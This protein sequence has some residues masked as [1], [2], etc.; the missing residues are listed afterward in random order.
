MDYHE[1]ENYARLRARLVDCVGK[2]SRGALAYTT[3]L[4]PEEGRMCAEIISEMKQTHKLAFFGGYD[5]AERKRAFILPDY[6]ESF[7]G[8]NNE[9]LKQYFRDE[10]DNLVSAVSITGSGYRELS[11]RDYMGSVLNLGIERDA[12]GDIVIQDKYSAVV[13]GTPIVCS[14]IISELLRVAS[15]KVSVKNVRIDENFRCERKFQPINDTVASK[16]FDCVVSALTNMSRD[17]AQEH[18]KAGLCELDYLPCDKCDKLIEPGMVITIRG[19]GKYIVRQSG[20]QTKKGRIR[21]T[22]DKYI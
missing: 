14:L 4:T 12:I 9:K 21:I 1:T 19:Y 13:F 6:L 5:D 17:K 16:R 20:E 18:I 7:D 8:E 10:L 11:H 2:S 3:F 15:D 22:V